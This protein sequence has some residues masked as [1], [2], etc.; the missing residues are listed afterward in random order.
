LELSTFNK[1]LKLSESLLSQ[2]SSTSGQ[3][4]S[5]NPILNRKE[6]LA[7]LPSGL[8]LRP[9]STGAPSAYQKTAPIFPKRTLEQPATVSSS[10]RGRLIEGGVHLVPG[11]SGKSLDA[12]ATEALTTGSLSEANMDVL[13]HAAGLEV[14][15]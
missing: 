6:A 2:K 15:S 13:L 5:G 12:A 7:S 9:I 1:L 4:P 11:L 8:A 10:K 14:G 3:A